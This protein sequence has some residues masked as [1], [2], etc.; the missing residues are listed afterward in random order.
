VTKIVLPFS[1]FKEHNMLTFNQALILAN[2]HVFTSGKFTDD[3]L[4]KTWRPCETKENILLQLV[5]EGNVELAK[6][7][8]KLYL[9]L[10]KMYNKLVCAFSD[11]TPTVPTIPS[12]EYIKWALDNGVCT[13]VKPF[14][15][16][17]V[18]KAK[19]LHKV[20]LAL[21]SY[22]STLDIRT[23]KNSLSFNR[24]H[25]DF[26]QGLGFPPSTLLMYLTEVIT[27]EWWDKQKPEVQRRIKKPKK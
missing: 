1:F 24:K 9:E 5:S 13:E 2:G 23:N 10:T 4:A 20:E 21:I 26:S 15:K 17:T 3:E 6:M 18:A 22:L 25:D 8:Q 19:N 27:P 11:T 12:N 16:K 7:E 14:H